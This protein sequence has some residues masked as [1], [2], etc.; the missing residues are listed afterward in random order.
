MAVSG[1]WRVLKDPRESCGVINAHTFEDSTVGGKI[2]EASVA[3][4]HW[5]SPA[6]PKGP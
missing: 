1:G 4:S 5:L 3:E 2:V 6:Y